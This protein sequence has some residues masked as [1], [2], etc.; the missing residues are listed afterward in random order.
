MKTGTRG[1]PRPKPATKDRILAAATAEFGLRGFEG[2]TV[3]RISAR[4]RLNKA[5]IYYHFD[6]KRALYTC[7]LRG[8]FTVMGDRLSAIAASEADPADKMDRFVAAFVLEGQTLSHIAPIML[9]EIAEGGRRLDEETYLVM[10]RVVRA[11]TDIVEQGR[12]TGQFADVDPMLLYLTTI[13][14][15]VVY[16]ATAPIRSA[17]ARVAHVDAARLD[18]ERFIRHMQMLNRRALMPAAAGARPIGELS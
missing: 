13:W 14:P 16:L 12:A 1:R 2:T 5:M 6:S 8:V 15:I 9:R 11:M 7:V 10:V 3:D 18:P 17:V 4:A